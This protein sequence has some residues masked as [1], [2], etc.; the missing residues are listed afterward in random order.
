MVSVETGERILRRIASLSGWS[1]EIAAAPPRELDESV[2]RCV[3]AARDAF[4]RMEPI[5]REAYE[6]KLDG[7]DPDEIAVAQ[8]RPAPLIRRD[9]D[10]ARQAVQRAV[11]ELKRHL[12]GQRT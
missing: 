1:R 4:D 2:A 10:A 6:M 11:A 9:L 5:R 7:M 3:D 8:G 12:R